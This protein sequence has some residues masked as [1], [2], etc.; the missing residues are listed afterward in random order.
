MYKQQN[1]EKKERVT[2]LNKTAIKVNCVKKIKGNE[3]FN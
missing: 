1:C 3:T 2:E